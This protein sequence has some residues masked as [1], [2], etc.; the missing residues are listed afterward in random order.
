MQRNR[1]WANPSPQA[2]SPTGQKTF[3]VPMSY[4][5]QVPKFL[6]VQYLPAPPIETVTTVT[7]KSQGESLTFYMLFFYRD[8][9]HTIVICP[10][11]KWML[12]AKQKL[13]KKKSSKYCCIKKSQ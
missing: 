8:I 3:Q 11:H 6:S 9:L 7:S 5:E 13:K 2:V 12:I 10:T 4:F 1:G